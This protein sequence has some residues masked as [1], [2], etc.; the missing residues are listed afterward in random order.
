LIFYLRLHSGVRLL[1]SCLLLSLLF[2]GH[3]SA[4]EFPPLSKRGT[5]KLF[6]RPFVTIGPN[7]FQLAPGA[8]II[9]QSNRIILPALLPAGAKIVYKLEEQTGFIRELWLLAP[10]ETVT[11]QQ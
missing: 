4:R 9:D 6:D 10:G 8:R 11:I 7:T 2:A 1:V 3:A 5:L